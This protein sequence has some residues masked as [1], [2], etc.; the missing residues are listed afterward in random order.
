[1]IVHEFIRL[2]T[3]LCGKKLI[4]YYLFIIFSHTLFVLFIEI[5]FCILW[6]YF[7]FGRRTKLK[8]FNSS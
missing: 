4:D 6:H 3:S 8:C 7:L 2:K 1:M 5:F